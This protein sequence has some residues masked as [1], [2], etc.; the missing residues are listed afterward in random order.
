MLDELKNKIINPEEQ[1]IYITHG[2]C[3]EDAIY[4][5]DLLMREIKV[6][7]VVINYLGPIIGTHTGPGLICIAFVGK[8][9]KI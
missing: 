8:G 2:D 4:L 1:T 3:I 9:R 7:N 5:R 6:K